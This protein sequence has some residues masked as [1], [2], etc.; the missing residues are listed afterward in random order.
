[1]ISRII[2]YVFFISLACSISACN[3]TKH[4]P[5]G[6][7]LFRGSKIVIK[8]NEASR[9]ERK[10]LK[11][12]LAGVVRPR[13]NSKFLGVR[14]KLS[15]YNLAGGDT[16]KKK[17]LKQW[18][19]NKVG[20]PPVLTSSV[21]L[22][23]NK[24][25]MVNLLQNRGFFE[26][27]AKARFDTNIH[28]KARAVFDITTGPQYTINKV[29]LRKDSSLIFHDIDSD[30]NQTLLKPGN[31]Y[32]L[33]VIKAERSR[34]DRM[35]KEK[36]YYYFRP[37]YILVL[38]DSSIGDHK[39]N[40]YVRLKRK[41]IPDEAYR[42]YTINDIYIYASYRLQ[43]AEKDTSKANKVKQDDYYIIDDKKAY[44]PKTLAD[45]ML[46]EKGEEYSL[47][48]QNTSLSRLVNMGTFKFVKNRF[49]PADDTLM[50]VYYYLTPF[51]KKS[52]RLE[53]GALTLNDN[54]TGTRASLSWRNRNAFKGAEELLFRVNAGIESQ[55]GS[56]MQP[57]INTFGATMQ[58]AFPRF[59]V[60]FIDVQSTSRYL[61]R[62]VIKLNATYESEVNLL[63]IISYSASYGYD[64]KE[65][66][67]KEHQL[68]P[69]NF[70]YVKTDTLNRS[71][72][73]HL[74]YSSLVFN[75]IIFG[76]T[77]EYTF[78]SQTGPS[79][80][81]GFYFDGLI[82]LSGDL[83]GLAQQPKSTASNQLGGG[84]S[85]AQYLKLQPDIRYYWHLSKTSTIAA[86][87]LAGIGIPYGGSSQ[88]PNIK[89]FW[90][91]GNSDLRG[92]PSRLVGP[93]T[94]NEASVYHTTTYL[95][96]LGDMKLEA[97]IELRQNIYKFVNGAL[98]ADAGN[99]WLYRDNPA[100]PGGTFTSNFLNQIAADVGFGIRLD[101]SI[102]LL[103]FDFGF[104]VMKPWTSA[105]I[106]QPNNSNSL[107]GNTVLNIAIGY[108]F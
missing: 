9:K 68:Y 70:T 87:A 22:D 48:D 10:V 40:M 95:E 1:M 26:A 103:R 21:H 35:L 12:D 50:N 44:K 52:I 13:P 94:F 108:P 4:L 45:A 102:L 5:Q 60:P 100:Y 92:F 75:G 57:P 30:F 49:E 93:G 62:T 85:F 33:D 66:P 106:Q 24:N 79:P 101:F 17:G 86:R 78:N 83:V 71:E 8:D 91:G 69:I 98:F 58:I 107:L 63:N 59:V 41:E 14:L 2:T 23:V 6:E 82:D 80:K 99:I 76:P 65:G 67:H 32:N 27:A 16:K 31:S 18:M 74:L 89:Q 46:F 53:L 104:P 73:L 43:G 3:N 84:L 15:L 64:W 38:V 61:P 77:Y 39:V 34:I 105:N 28:K 37:D 36:G 25:L 81:S 42:V 11:T 54:R 51:P 47:D 90:A 20:E 19:R 56:Q 7:R 88:L 96:T 72:Q 97:N 29:E 55:Y